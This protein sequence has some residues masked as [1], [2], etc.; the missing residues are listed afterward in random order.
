MNNRIKR[1][2]RERR[3]AVGVGGGGGREGGHGDWRG[4]G[5]PFNRKGKIPGIIKLEKARRQHGGGTMT[6]YSAQQAGRGVGLGA[7]L[8]AVVNNVY[9]AFHTIVSFSVCLT[10]F[11]G[12]EEDALAM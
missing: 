5:G 4:G 10:I 2:E 7:R 8:K 11:F 6:R 3:E 9:A 1:G 12:G